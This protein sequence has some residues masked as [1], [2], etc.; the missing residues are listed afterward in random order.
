MSNDLVSGI[1]LSSEFS[2]N[3]LPEL[4]L[5]FIGKLPFRVGYLTYDGTNRKNNREGLIVI[6][7]NEKQCK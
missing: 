6:R 4:Y 1:S 3:T 7:F 2:P 5:K